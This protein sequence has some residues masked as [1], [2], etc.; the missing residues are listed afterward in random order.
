MIRIFALFFAL[1]LPV[2]ATDL[3]VNSS[4]I[5]DTDHAIRITEIGQKKNR[6]VDEIESRSSSFGNFA[7]EFDVKYNT[8]EKGQP[9]EY[10][11]SGQ[12]LGFKEG[13]IKVAIAYGPIEIITFGLSP[14]EVVFKLA[15]DNEAY[16]G[17]LKEAQGGKKICKILSSDLC[18]LQM[19]FPEAWDP[20]ANCRFSRQE[21]GKNVIY[22]CSK[23][24]QS[25]RPIKKVCLKLEKGQSV[26]EKIV[27]YDDQGN[28]SGIISYSDYKP[29]T[30]DGKEY[31]LPSVVSLKVDENDHFVFTLKENRV[32]F[33]KPG[34]KPSDTRVIPSES[35][36]VLKFSDMR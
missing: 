16:V 35:N 6:A 20:N 21:G 26:I 13:F 31:L 10:L 18:G 25:I 36:S 19:F 3:A 34:A 32:R 12:V 17:T 2:L 30:I 14:K 11:L 5:Q 24:G 7:A 9:K 1:C 33:N 15:R 27:R 8:L 23:D 29:M 22:V 4:A 28:V